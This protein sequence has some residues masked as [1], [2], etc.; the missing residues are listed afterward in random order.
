MRVGGVDSRRAR[1]QHAM[2][3]HALRDAGARVLQ[4]PFMH[5]AY[6][7][8]FMKDSVLLAIH[9]GRVR[10]LPATLRH[11]V[12]RH[13]PPV[14]AAQLER[15]GVE[16]VQPLDTELEGGDVVAI[17]HRRLALM[18]YGV[19]SSERSARGV[20]RFLRCEVQP[21]ALRDP[22]LFHLDT[23]LAVLSDDTLILCERAFTPESLRAL[24]RLSFRR[25]IPVSDESALRFAVNVVEVNGTIITGTD[26]AQVARAF[27]RPV[28]VTPLTEFHLAGGSAACL[29]SRVLDLDAASATLAA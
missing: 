14:R 9:D 25:V 27:G 3:M 6:D 28:V 2:Y 8:V 4:L 13:E 20:G 26:D 12:R 7:S 18:G 23:A 10:A 1:A 22:A 24:G 15:T 16:I 17:P 11:D 29:V 5:G 21:L 19:R